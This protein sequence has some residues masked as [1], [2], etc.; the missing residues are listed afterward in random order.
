L[1][2]DDRVTSIDRSALIVHA[3]PEDASFATAQMHAARAAL[4]RGGH[5]VTVLDLYARRWDPVLG[6][7]EFPPSDGP[8]KPQ[9]A[10]MRAAEEGTLPSDVQAD[11]DALLAADLLVLSFPMWWFSM[12][13]VLKGWV[14]RGFVMG[15][16]FGGAHGLFEEAALAGRRAMVLATTG[17]PADAFRKGGAFGDL[18]EFLFHIHRGMLEFVGYEVLDP[19]VTYGPARLSGDER[20]QALAAV[21]DAFGKVGHSC[22]R[23]S[24]T[25]R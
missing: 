5:R 21:D 3:H 4:E 7:E 11:L 15:A 10:Q 14:D 22:G 19:V 25:A 24:A 23:R 12:P 16:V 8:F 9:V 13:A 6:Q 2:Y 1:Q 17:G 18:D 20:T